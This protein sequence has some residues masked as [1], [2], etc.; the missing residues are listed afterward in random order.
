MSKLYEAHNHILIHTNSIKPIAHRH[1]AAHIILS[2]DGKMQV[3]SNRTTYQCQGIVIPS[4]L[5]H[6]VE[7][8]G[9][10]VLVFLY[11]CATDVAKHITKIQCIPA[12]CCAKIAALYA[13][14]DQ[15]RTASSYDT[16]E[17]GCL[18]QL[19]IKESVCR[20]TDERILSAMHYI[21]SM[22]SE[23][24]SC[25]QVSDAVHLSEGRFSHLFKEQ[26]G[27]P[28]ASYLIYQRILYAYTKILQGK[29]ITEAALEAGFASSSHFASINRRVFGIT[30]SNI[31]QDLIFT[32]VAE[33]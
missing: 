29:S 31:T 10:P 11:D 32:K 22:S 3:L 4:G 20:V 28:F 23:K 14:F 19:G 7:P 26:V 24:I 18:M 5:S 9:N 33:I 17:K 13:I 27:M 2:L 15:E 8:C 25:Q 16:F 6:I 1:R 30:A 12:E 21:R